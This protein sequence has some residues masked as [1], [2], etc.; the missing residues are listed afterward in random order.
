MGKIP[1]TIDYMR[2]S[3]AVE[4][5]KTFSK[6][7]KKALEVIE[8]IIKLLDDGIPKYTLREIKRIE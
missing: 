5:L 4:R 8:E 1:V 3:N 7:N 6:N 2:M